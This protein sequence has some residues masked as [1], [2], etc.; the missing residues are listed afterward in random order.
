MLRM[1]IVFI[2]ALSIVMPAFSDDNGEYVFHR[3]VSL[4]FVP[5]DVFFFID[6]PERTGARRIKGV[7]V[8]AFG[9]RSLR[10]DSQEWIAG[11]SLP[12]SS[13]VQSFTY[14]AIII[15]AAGRYQHLAPVVVTVADEP[16][17]HL[18]TE[19]LQEVLGE[20]KHQLRDWQAQYHAQA[21]SISRLKED[22]TVIARLERV[23]NVEEQ[24]RLIENELRNTDRDLE[25]L[26]IFLKVAKQSVVPRNFARRERDLIKQLADLA[27][28]T[29]VAEGEELGRKAVAEEELQRKLRMVERTRAISAERLLV[30]LKEL[31]SRRQSLEMQLGIADSDIESEEEY[32]Q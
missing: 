14:A 17:G 32:L 30:R 2:M 25:H 13:S 21:D 9:E 4:N 10:S 26:K 5:E 7:V 27:E 11:V 24:I 23:E 6:I 20:S 19:E 3:K 16:A 12:L 22:A 29:S 15:G 31:R 28:A 18:S 8:P 1:L